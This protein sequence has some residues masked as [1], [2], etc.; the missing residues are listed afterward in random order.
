MAV[1]ARWLSRTRIVLHRGELSAAVGNREN[2][3]VARGAAIVALDDGERVAL[4]E[5]SP[6][7]GYSPDTLDACVEALRDIHLALG[8]L[9]VANSIEAA[10]RSMVAPVEERLRAVPAA[11]YA[12]ETALWSYAKLC[13]KDEATSAERRL[14]ASNRDV[15][16]SV[17]L[18]GGATEPESWA[19]LARARLAHL[20]S[21]VGAFKVKV[22]R[23]DLP[24][25]RELD[26]V[27]ALRDA[28]SSECELRV[29]CNGAW[30]VDEAR[31]NIALLADA[32]ASSIEEPCRGDALLSLGAQP[33]PWLADESLLVPAFAQRVL[34]APGC[35]GLVLKPTLLGGLFACVD[36][37]RAASER[38]IRCA[39]SHM[40]EGPI[41]LKSMRELASLSPLL[42]LPSSLGWHEGLDAWPRRA[43]R[44]SFDLEA[45][46]LPWVF[47]AISAEEWGLALE[48]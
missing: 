21:E 37:M 38:G 39:L 7:P 26:G 2:S 1:T 12:L 16:R 43:R 45:S 17:L 30:S 11:R 29:D 46:H 18:G 48:P 6:L 27:R 4:G 40:F 19:S 31:A 33:I 41:A 22:G 14:E 28:V 23:K 5:A 3:W 32:G 42:P 34:D 25:A 35:G 10:V 24:F 20:G 15:L 36:L 13:A 9:N 47:Y 8:P 44:S